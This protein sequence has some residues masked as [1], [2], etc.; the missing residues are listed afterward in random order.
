VGGPP[1]PHAGST[2]GKRSPQRGLCRP[3]L[4]DRSLEVTIRQDLCASLPCIGNQPAPPGGGG[5]GGGWNC[6]ASPACPCRAQE[7][8]TGRLCLF[9]PSLQIYFLRPHLGL[10]LQRA[11]AA[12]G[13][14]TPQWS[15]ALCLGARNPHKAW[16]T[17]PGRPLALNP[18][19][20]PPPA[21]LPRCLPLGSRPWPALGVLG[22]QACAPHCTAFRGVS[23]HVSLEWTESLFM[24]C[25]LRQLAGP[26]L[27]RSHQAGPQLRSLETHCRAAV[28][29]G[30]EEP[31]VSST[32]S[33]PFPWG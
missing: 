4:A 17:R 7:H 33:S 13:C 26:S 27:S 24:K 8:R 9:S 14:E 32:C 20:R 2:A 15:R 29:E 30:L 21:R 25:H 3:E 1:R 28:C 10:L 12:P 23:L 18:Q 22:S 31:R 6:W 16:L 19:P 5:R 11:G